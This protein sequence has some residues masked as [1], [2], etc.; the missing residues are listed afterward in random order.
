[1]PPDSTR[2][3]VIQDVRFGMHRQEA[4]I[5]SQKA[6]MKSLQRDSESTQDSLN[7]WDEV[8]LNSIEGVYVDDSIGTSMSSVS[9]VTE[10]AISDLPQAGSDPEQF[11]LRDH[12]MP[13]AAPKLTAA[14]STPPAS[15]SKAP[16]EVPSPSLPSTSL[17]IEITAPTVTVT[18]DGGPKSREA[19]AIISN[20]W[21]QPTEF[22]SWNI[23]FKSEVTH[24]SQYPR[25]A[26]LWIGEV[27]DAKSIDDLITSASITGKSK[28]D[29]E[30]LDVN[31]ASG[32]R[33]ILTGSFKKQVTTAE[34][35]TQSEKSSL[36]DRQVAWMIYD[37]FKISG[38]NEAI[39]DFRHLSKN[40]LKNDNVQ[41][42]DTKWD[43]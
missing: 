36:T 15:I 17:P 24:S 40:Q 39:L 28:P 2:D 32:L 4:K 31:I 19:E 10:P 6:E 29:F 7:K 11:Q 9:R 37:L 12:P 27:E 33:K 14:P 22:R 23:R 1:M 8:N 41:A 42:F 20:E 16:F 5:E 30:N 3:S 13:K 38:N 26:M 43:E 35:K 21:P 25:D 34:G 18:D